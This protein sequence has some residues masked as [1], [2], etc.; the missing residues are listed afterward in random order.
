MSL[1]IDSSNVFYLILIGT[2]VLYIL[3]VMLLN[4]LFQK[5]K[6]KKKLNSLAIK[7][8]KKI[9]VVKDKNNG[10]TFK[11]KVEDK[12]YTAKL[13]L[14]KKN[15]DLQINNID[16]WVMYIKSGDT[17]KCKSIPNMTVF[18]NYKADNKIVILANQVKTIKKVINECE[19]IMVN[20]ETNVHGVNVYNLNQLDQLIK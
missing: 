7:H 3:Y 1:S 11:I 18:M 5:I 2:C 17:F 16:T 6:I 10:S 8:N 13:I 15:C 9:I 12:T 20:N 4:P 14:T 19:M